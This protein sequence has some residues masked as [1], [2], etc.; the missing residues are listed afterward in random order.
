MKWLRSHYR[1]LTSI[2][3]LV[4]LSGCCDAVNE[5]RR[6]CRQ[7]QQ[8]SRAF[9]RVWDGQELHSIRLLEACQLFVTVLET[10]G[11]QA[12]K[13][14]F[15]GNFCK[16]QNLISHAKTSSFQVDHSSLRD[17]LV[18]ERDT[19]KIHKG[20]QLKDPSGAVGLLWMRRSLE[21]QTVL[22]LGLVQGKGSKEAAI[23]AY[24]TRLQPY[25]GPVLRRFYTTFF[26]Y[27]MPSKDNILRRLGDL[28][29]DEN[30]DSVVNELV[31]LTQCWKRILVK[32]KQDFVEL[33]ME[34]CRQV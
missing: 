9:E 8:L 19:L 29:D 23:T 2:S 12:V 3:L 1:P 34:D 26:R 5:R 15:V 24:E 32:W 16:A 18:F 11:P 6:P 10:T 13:R 25:H 31:R 14:D 30:T 21:F 7:L 20:K 27:Q 17:L 22:Y 28:R 4:L 33:D